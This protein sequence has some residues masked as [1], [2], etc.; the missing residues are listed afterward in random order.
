MTGSRSLRLGLNLPYT[1]G[2][3]AGVTPHWADI[4]AMA[5]AAEAVGFDAIWVSDHVGFGD[6]AADKPGAWNGAW[7]SWTLLSGLAA[8]TTRVALGT[9]V[10]CSPFRNP[11][12]LAKMAETLDEV[13]GGASSSASGRAGTRSS[14]RATA[15]RSPSASTAL[16]TGCGSSRPSSGR[17]ARRMSAGASRPATPG[18]SRAGRARLGCRSWS[19][20]AG[21]GCSA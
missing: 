9:Y 20:R 7:E 17:A 16:R 4:R 18:S 3:M 5:C 19:A 6:P 1:E 2:Q 14:S 12:L 13:S 15:I 11:A 10:L 8:A 21:R